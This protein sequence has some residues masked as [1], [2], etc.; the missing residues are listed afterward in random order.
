MI[1]EWLGRVAVA[2]SCI[3]S[4]LKCVQRLGN[5]IASTCGMHFKPAETEWK[6]DGERAAGRQASLK[7]CRTTGLICRRANCRIWRRL[8][9]HICHR[10]RHVRGAGANDEYQRYAQTPHLTSISIL[11]S[12]C[13]LRS[14]KNRCLRGWRWGLRKKTTRHAV[15]VVCRCLADVPIDTFAWCG[16]AILVYSDG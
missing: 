14:L 2:D 9:P 13:Y 4:D 5:C 16:W 6:K 12:R 8:T 3:I 10:K 15:F 1:N 7:D 11:S